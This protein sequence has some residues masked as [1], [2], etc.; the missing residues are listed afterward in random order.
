M[1]IFP[2]AGRR[3]AERS[4]PTGAYLLRQSGRFAGYANSDVPYSVVTV[5]GRWYGKVP[6]WIG[7]PFSYSGVALFL[8]SAVYFVA[9][10]ASLTDVINAYVELAIAFSLIIV[11]RRLQRLA[12]RRDVYK[13]AR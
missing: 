4:P 5:Q 10:A 1:Y 12:E 13:T 8:G 9:F 6:Q 2:L 7:Y 3:G 11:G